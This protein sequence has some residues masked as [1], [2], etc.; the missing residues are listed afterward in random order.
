MSDMSESGRDIAFDTQA[1]WMRRFR[2]DAESNL[3]AFALRL[4][5]AMPERVSIQ[6]S[7]GFF[8]R[9]AKTTGVS[10]DMDQNRYV[11]EIANGRLKA[12]VA[13]VVRGIAISTKDMDPAEWFAKLSEE[14]K[15]ASEHAKRLA[16]SLSAF[17]ST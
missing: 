17:M 1:A 8:S 16:Q 3:H 10:V 6:Q 15:T 9:V 11:L 5:E 13:M 14:T 12:S 7:K 4:H 2:S